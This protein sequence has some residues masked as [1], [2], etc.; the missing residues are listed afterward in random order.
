MVLSKTK[1][2]VTTGNTTFFIPV[3]EHG[4]IAVEL[5]TKVSRWQCLGQEPW[6]RRTRHTWAPGAVTIQQSY[7]LWNA[8]YKPWNCHTVAS[9]GRLG[10]VGS[11]IGIGRGIYVPGRVEC[12]CIPCLLGATHASNQTQTPFYSGRAGYLIYRLANQMCILFAGAA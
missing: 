10:M 4:R 8:P 1:K 6:E 11:P 12:G 9:Q 7:K 5:I 3:F 2:S